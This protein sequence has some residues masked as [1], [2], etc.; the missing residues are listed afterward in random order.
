MLAGAA[1]SSPG[2]VVRILV[3]G[4]LECA[5]DV[6][7]DVSAS[8]TMVAAGEVV[9]V[10]LAPGIIAYRRLCVGLYSEDVS[11]HA[12]CVT[13]K[14]TKSHRKVR[15]ARANGENVPSSAA[16]SASQ[17]AWDNDPDS[18]WGRCTCRCLRCF[19]CSAAPKRPVRC[20]WCLASVSAPR[21]SPRL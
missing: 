6:A 2:V 9:E 21:Q 20:S 17:S 10:L 7:K 8:A 5:V 14:H 11:V 16:A 4:D 19:S 15:H 3:Q 18:R 12:P 13:P 1:R